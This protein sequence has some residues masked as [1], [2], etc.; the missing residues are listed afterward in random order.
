M[1]QTV[2]AFVETPELAVI[3][4]N[5]VPAAVNWVTTQ[6]GNWLSTPNDPELHRQIAR[7]IRTAKYGRRDAQW[8][9]RRAIAH[10]RELVYIETALFAATAQASG[11]PGDPAAAAELIVE[12][13]SRLQAEP[14]LRVVLLTPREPPFVSAYE[15]F[16]AHFYAERLK[17]AQSLA[18]AGGNVDGLNGQRPRV[19]IAHPVGIPGRPLVIRT[20]TVIVDDVW[21]L[22][23]ASTLTR[24]GLTFDGANTS[25]L[26]TGRLT[27]ARAQPFAPIVR[28]SWRSTS[29]R[30]DAGGR[31]R[32]TR[33]RGLPERRLGAAAST[34]KCARGVRRHPR[35]RQP[36][37]ASAALGGA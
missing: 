12:L 32:A 2:P 37:Q 8:A 22:S 14:R 25:S 11:G 20:T 10:A 19:V 3:S 16:S 31:R 17:A 23:G 1:L 27:G 7:E 35:K 33:C 5:D 26:S 36:W 21:C 34:R 24:R 6:L 4:D 18:L 29:G 30:A 15:P 9:L 28:R 13:A